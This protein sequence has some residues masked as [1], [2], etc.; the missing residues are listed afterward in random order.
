MVPE[1]GVVDFHTLV[2]REHG[3]VNQFAAVPSLHVGWT[4]LCC[5][6]IASWYKARWWSRLI[7]LQALLMIVVVIVTGNHYWIDGLIGSMYVLIPGLILFHWQSIS[8]WWRMWIRP[9]EFRIHDTV[10]ESVRA[11]GWAMLTWTGLGI[12]L[13]I[14]LVGQFVSPGFTSYWGYMVFQI[15]A[16]IM[17][18]GILTHAFA[19]EGGLSWI[20]HLIIIGVTYA[21]TLG[22]AAGF[23]ERFNAFDK[24]THI[25][26][27]MVLS[28]TMFE[29]LQAL[30]IRGGVPLA[31]TLRSAIAV[32]FA[33]TMGG[34]WEF[35]ELWG[36]ALFDT[37]RHA[38]YLDTTYDM[39]SDSVGAIGATIM[40]VI[41]EPRRSKVLVSRTS[42]LGS[43]SQRSAVTENI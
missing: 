37:G 5:F 8:Q 36:D 6:V 21:D 33:I 2:G 34:M 29:I 11:S 13:A 27:G 9:P 3:F 14:L 17:L 16:T 30:N 10:F 1:A 19:R 39:I 23:Y 40:L 15:S 26:G 35:Y 4:V 12:L 20:T 31:L 25:A 41:L 38:G 32:G 18:V 42:Q 24:I 28:A 7:W 22:T 43:I